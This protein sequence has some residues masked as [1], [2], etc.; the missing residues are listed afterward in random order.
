[1]VSFVRVR[2]KTALGV[3]ASRH[4]AHATSDRM[5]VLDHPKE[6]AVDLARHLRARPNVNGVE[7]MET[8]SCEWMHRL[9]MTVPGAS[10][11]GAR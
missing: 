4:P 6:A 10:H 2:A 11:S 7:V 9:R 3:L 8:H 5:A 1:M